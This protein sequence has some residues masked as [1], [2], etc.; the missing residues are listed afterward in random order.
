MVPL[1]DREMHA[2]TNFAGHHELKVEDIT[3][4]TYFCLRRLSI[5]YRNLPFL[6]TWLF[7]GDPLKIAGNKRKPITL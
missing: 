7:K 5:F 6:P 1:T 2:I 4:E 3:L